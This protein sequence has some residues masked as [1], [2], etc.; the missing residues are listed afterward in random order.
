MF[1]FLNKGD[2]IFSLYWT[3]QMMYLALDTKPKIKKI[4]VGK[5]RVLRPARFHP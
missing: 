3:L 1:C 4:E 2:H 5:T